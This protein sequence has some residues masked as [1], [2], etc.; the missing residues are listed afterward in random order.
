MRKPSHDSP[1]QLY[2]SLSVCVHVRACARDYACACAMFS[3]F[4]HHSESD[5]LLFLHY[6]RRSFVSPIY[7]HLSPHYLLFLP[8]YAGSFASPVIQMNICFSKHLDDLLFLPLFRWSFVSTNHSIS[9]DHLF[10]PC[11]YT[12]S[13]SKD[14]VYKDV[15]LGNGQYLRT[16]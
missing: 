9:D 1:L 16:L 11:D 10:P 6:L 4:S 7:V 3:F 12:F 5:D 2:L 13:F 15:R 14:T 8:T